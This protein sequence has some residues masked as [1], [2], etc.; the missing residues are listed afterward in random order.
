MEATLNE[1]LKNYNNGYNV[2]LI[3]DCSDT[4]IRLLNEANILK[5][6]TSILRLITPNGTFNTPFSVKDYFNKEFV[7]NK[8]NGLVKNFRLIKSEEN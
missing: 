4:T 6:N 1:I 8:G 7:G 5:G 3:S 2:P